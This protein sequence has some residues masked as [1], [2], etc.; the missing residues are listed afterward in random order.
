MK[1]RR[2]IA[3]FAML[4]ALALSALA[5]PVPACAVEACAHTNVKAQDIAWTWKNTSA[6]ASFHCGDCKQDI[7][8]AASVTSALSGTDTVVF[9]ASVNIGGHTFTHSTIMPATTAAF[10]GDTGV[11][12]VSVYYRASS[13]APDETDAKVAAA[14]NYE[15]GAPTVDGTGGVIFSVNLKPGY[16]VASVT[17][18]AGTYGRIMAPKDTGVAGIWCITRL[19]GSTIINIATKYVGST[20]WVLY[21]GHYYYVERDGTL[22]T[23]GWASYRGEWYHLDANG[24]VTVN[25]WVGYKGRKYFLGSGGTALK[26]SWLKYGDSWYY[27][28]ADGAAYT[29]QWLAFKGAYYYFDADSTMVFDSWLEYKD[30]WYRFGEDGK[31]II[32]DWVAYKGAYYYMGADGKLATD[33]W[34][35]YDGAYYYVGEDGKPYVNAWLEY[36]GAWYRFGADGKLMT[37]SWVKT[38]KGYAYVGT[39]GKAYAEKWL[40]YEGAWYYFGA[41]GLPLANTSVTLDGIR[42]DFDA[43]GRCVKQTKTA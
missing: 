41:D 40:E 8:L 38:S 33:T 24:R 1:M 19:T 18:T 25:S 9:T 3:V 13:A 12:S 26:S 16:A 37:E 4:L 7:S 11:A 29:E 39:D 14:R 32:S 6:M 21:D 2:I 22:R 23:N 17:A 42:Y 10:E 36:E 28:G 31:L 34:V 15:S 30:A 20:G 27:F 43:K 5:A 35:A